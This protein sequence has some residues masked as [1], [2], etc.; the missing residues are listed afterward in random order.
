MAKTIDDVLVGILGRSA[1]QIASLLAQ[2]EQLVEDLA[3]AKGESATLKA[4]PAPPKV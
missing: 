2:V 3:K 1:L 4:A